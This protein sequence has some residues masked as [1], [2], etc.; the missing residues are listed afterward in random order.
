M[1]NCFFIIK[2]LRNFRRERFDDCCRK[3]PVDDDVRERLRSYERS[4]VIAQFRGD[5]LERVVE[6]RASPVRRDI[7]V[8]DSGNNHEN[9]HLEMRYT[10]ASTSASVKSTISTRP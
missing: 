4:S 5:A 10:S 3:Q 8:S 7:R 9:T 6:Q 1:P 2:T